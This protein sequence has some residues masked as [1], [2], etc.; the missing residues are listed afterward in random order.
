MAK[1]TGPLFSMSASGK[2]GDAV[3][4]GAW[5]GVNTVRQWLKPANP[6]TASQGDTRIAMGGTGRG[7]GKMVAE[8]SYH[9]QLI[10]LELIPGG[11]TKQSYMVQ[12]ILD[13]YLTNAT[14]YSAMQAELVAHTAYTSFGALADTKT[15][16]EFDDG[17]VKKILEHSWKKILL[18]TDHR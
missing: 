1:V 16:L 18:L 10:D 7:V 2:L 3:V 6:Q 9:Q 15:I 11:Q 12:Y 17:E 4:Y 5:K 13:H 14:T 8:S